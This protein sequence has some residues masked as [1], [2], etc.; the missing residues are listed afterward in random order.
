MTVG[1]VLSTDRLERSRGGYG[2]TTRNCRRCPE[3]ERTVARKLYGWLAGCVSA[4]VA[5]PRA[6]HCENVRAYYPRQLRRYVR[7][8]FPEF[9]RGSF[10][11]RGRVVPCARRE[12][13][14]NKRRGTPMVRGAYFVRLIAAPAGLDNGKPNGNPTLQKDKNKPATRR[15]V[16]SRE[17]RVSKRINPRART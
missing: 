12:T 16:S 15:S 1:A 3:L 4:G 11:Y 14:E 5:S 7:A 6:K 8:T 9:V 2:C 10:V 17:F 13:S